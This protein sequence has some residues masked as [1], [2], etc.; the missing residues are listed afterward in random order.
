L[1]LEAEAVIGSGVSS[2]SS[3]VVHAGFYY[4]VGS[5]RAALC[6]AGRRQLDRFLT[7]HGVDYD[8][9]GKLL[10]ASSPEEIGRIEALARQGEDN[11][12]EGL[13]WLSQNQAEAL[14]PELRAVAALLSPQSGVFDSHGY[15][16]ALQHEI[17]D[18]G[19]LVVLTT[20]F[21]G[22]EP[23]AGGGYSIRTGGKDPTRVSCRRLVLSAGL[24]AQ[25]VAGRVS[26]FPP[27]RIPRRYL[28]KGSYFTLAGPAPFRRLVYPPPIPG[29][30][31]T[32][33]RRD[34]GGQA[35]FGPDLEYID[36]VDYHL[37]ASRAERFYEAIRRY[38]PSLPDGALMPDYVGIRPKLHGPNDPQPDFVIDGPAEHG[39]EGLCAL[40]GIESPGLTSSL[41]IGAAVA[42]RLALPDRLAA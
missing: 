26:G 29:A 35:R 30:L 18:R 42:T 3:E 15:M 12:V 4:P 25:A 32:H 2:R 10:V 21:E 1:V 40:F 5:V 34:L 8:P 39:M 20:P 17:E 13:T 16:R 27:E 33:Y 11:G 28:G 6:V 23:M 37:D 14:E 24:G 7:A 19:G 36:E 31:G 22:A 38:W 41:A 9:C